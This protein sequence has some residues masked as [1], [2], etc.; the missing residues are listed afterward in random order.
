[1][2]TITPM[3]NRLNFHSKHCTYL[4]MAMALS[5]MVGSSAKAENP[6]S[7][8][9]PVTARAERVIDGD[10]IIVKAR[11]WLRQDITVHVRL[12]GIDAPELSS[13]H[14]NIRSRGLRARA[15][16]KNLVEGRKLTMR[17]IRP[18]KYAGRVIAQLYLADGT[19]LSTHLLNQ[20]LAEPYKKYKRRR[21]RPPQP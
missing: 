17:N 9:G 19:N 10:T 20:G 16:L 3:A 15:E 12:S 2:V 11:I 14:E 8:K 18:G 7:M 13:P 4:V 5:L 1:M 6:R 21:Y